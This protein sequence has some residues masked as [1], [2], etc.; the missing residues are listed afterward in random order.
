MKI[1][2]LKE[3][4]T[5]LK[6]ARLADQY[7]SVTQ[8]EQ[9]SET[10]ETMHESIVLRNRLSKEIKICGY[11]T[12]LAYSIVNDREYE[13]YV[14]IG[15]HRAYTSFGVERLRSKRKT[16]VLSNLRPWSEDP[17]IYADF[18]GN[19]GDII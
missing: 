7:N 19:H 5:V 2:E 15:N 17:D 12:T 18:I 16:H 8:E 1:K 11:K 3:K 14:E 13:I 6:L 9:K 4:N 10:L